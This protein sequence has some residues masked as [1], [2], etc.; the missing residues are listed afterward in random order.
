MNSGMD[1][2]KYLEVFIEEATENLQDLNQALLELENNPEEESNINNIFRIAHTLKGMSATMDF[3]RMSKLTHKMEDALQE[4]RSKEIKLDSELID[5]LFNG[6]DALESYLKNIVDYSDEG[7]EEYN[8]I[9]EALEKFKNTNNNEKGQGSEASGKN[10]SNK[11]ALDEKHLKRINIYEM[12]V[13]NKALEINLFPYYININLDEGCVLK[14]ARAY[15]IFQVLE[16]YSDIIRTEPPVEDIEDEK[17]EFSFSVLVISKYPAETLQK[18]L[19]RIS[20]VESVT[21]EELKKESIIVNLE[22]T[23]LEKQGK[24]NFAQLDS[25]YQNGRLKDAIDTAKN[26]INAV[27]DMSASKARLNV[28]KSVRVDIE[29]LD[30]LLNLVGELIIQ[31]TRLEDLY[32]DKNQTYQEA[33][34]YLERIITNLHEAVMKVRMVP[35]E[36][37]FNRF[38]RMIRD[39]SRK[40][41]KEIVLTMSGEETELDRTIIDE[42][43]EPIVHLL[44]N[45][46]DHGIEKPQ[47]RL[48]KGKSEEG[49]VFLKAYQ[50]GNN[51]IIEVADDGGGIN[52]EK[53]RQ[54]AIEKGVVTYDEVLNMSENETINLLFRPGMSTAN[55]VSDISGRGVGLDVVKNKIESLGGVVEIESETNKGS[56]FIIR[57]PLTLAMIQALLVFIGKER[58]AIPLSSIKQIVKIRTEEVKLV[59]KREVI[60]INDTIVPLVWLD[61]VLGCSNENE[62]KNVVTAIIINKGGKLFA[63]TV[64]S[65]IGQQEIVI[66]NLGKYLSDIKF[67]SGGTILGDGNVALI[68]DVNYI[69][70][71]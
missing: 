17:F 6:L 2:N 48:S 43:G 32:D 46:I 55:V 54:K 40:L 23:A 11:E 36:T 68:L 31:K 52:L 60:F 59:Q 7:V 29:K 21:I 71:L 49:H 35:V 70:G 12:N 47:E 50:E 1:T 37:V 14:S 34:Q 5:I 57:L 30:V 38:P 24:S 41:N 58:Y 28:V 56:R 10:K 64:D 25:V 61:R 63:L 51:V 44:R 45:S 67:V 18:E 69:A 66:K 3:T 4:V 33:I 27:K 62:R 13:I 42:I 53:V 8:H 26:A 19:L 22:D 15:V 9:I 39:L 16:K 65:L 20:E